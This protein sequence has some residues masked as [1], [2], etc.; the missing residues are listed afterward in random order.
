MQIKWF[1]EPVTPIEIKSK[2]AELEKA[3]TKQLPNCYKGI[4][5]NLTDFIHRAFGVGLSDPKNL[6]PCSSR[7]TW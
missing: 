6:I 5:H 1:N 4:L 2:D 7:V 3:T